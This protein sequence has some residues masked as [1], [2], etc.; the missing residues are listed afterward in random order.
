MKYFTLLISSLLF[1]LPFGQSRA[2]TNVI[3]AGDVGYLMGGYMCKSL[4]TTGSL[5]DPDVLDEFAVEAMEMYSDEE[6][7]QFLSLML[8]LL[9]TDDIGENPQ[10]IEL[11][12]GAFTHIIGDDDCF[13]A[14]LR[15]SQGIGSERVLE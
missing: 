11:M 4:L 5:N 2:E 9:T 15:D 3:D 8:G 14:F 1:M 12:R 10:S 7:E 13:K 6:S